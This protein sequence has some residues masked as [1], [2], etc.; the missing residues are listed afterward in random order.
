MM[1]I[2][3]TPQEAKQLRAEQN[4]VGYQNHASD[5]LAALKFSHALR[6]KGLTRIA[7]FVE[8]A[9]F[10]KID[11]ESESLWRSLS[12]MGGLPPARRETQVDRDIAYDRRYDD[13]QRACEW[14]RE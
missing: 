6:L 4:A 9:A 7:D 1:E 13:R 10:K 11:K 3:L 2:E 14:A 5:S 12:G 8:E